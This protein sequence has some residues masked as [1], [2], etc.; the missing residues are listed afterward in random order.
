MFGHYLR[1][2]FI[3]QELLLEFSQGVVGAVVVQIQ[4]V[5]HIPGRNT[6][7][8]YIELKLVPIVLEVKT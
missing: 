3:V 4:G 5:Q 2:D 8:T 6:C 7:F 1:L